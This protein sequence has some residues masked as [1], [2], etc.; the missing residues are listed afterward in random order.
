LPTC[1]L[2]VGGSSAILQTVKGKD[3]LL[4]AGKGGV[5]IALDPDKIL[6]AAIR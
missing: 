2:T 3:I 4:A 1:R 5:A 6:H